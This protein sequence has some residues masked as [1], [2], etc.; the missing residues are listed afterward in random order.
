MRVQVSK[1]I[2]AGEMAI[3]SKRMGKGLW[4]LWIS[5]SNSSGKF[6]KLGVLMTYAPSAKGS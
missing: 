4:F 3:I 1:L 6:D 5:I 2:I